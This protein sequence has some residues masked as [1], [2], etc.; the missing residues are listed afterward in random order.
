MCDGFGN[1]FT[2][3]EDKLCVGRSRLYQDI[4][5]IALVGL[6]HDSLYSILRGKALH[7]QGAL[8][9]ND[10]RVPSSWNTVRVALVDFTESKVDV[11]GWCASEHWAPYSENFS[12][13]YFG[14]HARTVIVD[15]NFFRFKLLVLRLTEFVF[16]LKVYP[17]LEAKGPLFEASRHLSMDDAF[18]SRHPLD[19]TRAN[20]ASRASEVFMMYF[21]LKHVGDSLKTT[22][23]VVWKSCW[24]LDIKKVKQEEGV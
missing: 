21:T 10:H 3:E 20:D 18:A 11:V 14:N 6:E 19:T 7:L 13:D 12:C 2:G 9:Q 24:E 8:V 1:R 15:W 23:G 4:L 5:L 16:R 22:V 17:Q